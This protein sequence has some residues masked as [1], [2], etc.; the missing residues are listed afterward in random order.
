MNDS[1]AYCRAVEAHLCRRNEGTLIRIVGPAFDLVKGW[2]EA[3]I[4]LAV[5]CGG[6]DRYV[7]RAARKGPRRR[8]IRVE[9]CEADVREAFDAWTRAVGVSA[10]TASPERAAARRASLTHHIDRVVAQLTTLR[11]TGR[12]PVALDGALAATV[13]A[14]D[15]LRA[16]SGSARGAAR[17]A[18]IAEL[19]ALD[20]TLIDAA[21]TA[22]AP[23]DRAEIQRAAAAE[24]APFKRRLAG[25]QWEAAVAAAAGSLLRLRLGLPGVAFD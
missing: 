1:H 10:A 7:D 20:R 2:A 9:F 13:N 17:E 21:L 16:G 4:P 8:P 25:A 18:L 3:G 11:G 15:A 19:A 12:A 14:V 23:A 24:I 5:A 22:V 6:I